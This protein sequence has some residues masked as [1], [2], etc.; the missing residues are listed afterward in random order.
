MDISD[1]EF[2]QLID[3]I[4][5]VSKYDFRDYSDKSLRR[6][7]LKIL[8]DFR[9][10]ASELLQRLTTQPPFLEEVVKRITVNTTEMFRDPAVWL[11]LQHNV[12]PILAKKERIKIWHAGCSSGQEVY[13]MIMLLTELDLLDRADLY[14]SDLNENVI[15]AAK[16]GVYKFR[17][18][19]S[20]LANFDKVIAAHNPSVEK[21]VLYQKYFDL[22]TIS[23]QIKIHQSLL[24]KPIFAKQDLVNEPN[25][26]DTKFDLIMC[27]NVIIYFNY[28]LQNRIFELSYKNLSDKGFL[29]LGLHESIHGQYLS[30]F[31]KKGYHYEKK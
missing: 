19:I 10:P 25:V 28:N 5:S 4:H 1:S 30:K 24:Q 22:D 23:D 13:S 8:L 15:D 21:E 20:Y 26:F 27:R 6:R 9:I 7:F 31:E 3:V 18:N 12:L 2:E 29:L 16:K 14:A 11:D 17:F